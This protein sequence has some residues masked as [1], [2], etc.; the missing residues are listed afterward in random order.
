MTYEQIFA[1]ALKLDAAEPANLADLL[2]ISVDHS[3]NVSATWVDEAERRDKA[4]AAGE[5]KAASHEEILAEL[6][7]R[8]AGMLGD[9]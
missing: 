9:S 3:D 1:A 4:F 8:Y 6:R 2:W 7:A 5:I